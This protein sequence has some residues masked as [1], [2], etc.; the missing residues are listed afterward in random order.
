[1]KFIFPKKVF[2]WLDEREGKK[3]F[4]LARLDSNLGVA[5]EIGS[6]EGKSAICL[7]QG[8]KLVSKEKVYSVDNFVGDPYVGRN[9]KMLQNF[10][11]NIKE[12]GFEKHIEAIKADSPQAAKNFNKPI[13]LLFIDASHDYG[14]VK[15]DFL[16]WFPHVA[17]GGFVAFHDTTS[18]EGVRRFTEELKEAD[19]LVYL[20]TVA[21]IAIFKKK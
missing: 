16:A 1:M 19:K 8:N 6:Y 10:L 14:S 5:V 18:F 21:S 7:A 12:A 3:L 2:G 20:E 13:R 11:K 4:E 9:P 17:S 15:K